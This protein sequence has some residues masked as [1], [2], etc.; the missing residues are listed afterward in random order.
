MKKIL[1]LGDSIR[2]GYE[3]YVKQSFDGV[4]DVYFP[5]VNCAFA[6][7]MLR[8]LNIWKNEQKIPDD[9]DLVHFNVGLWDVLRIYDDGTLTSPEY[10]AEILPRIIKRIKILFP[11]A[12]IVFALSTNVYEE[13]YKTTPPYARLNADVEKFNKIAVD[14]L[15][16]LGVFINDLYAITKDLPA[17]S[18][19]R[20][21]MTHFNTDDGVN[22]LGGQV[23]KTIC[24]LLDIPLESINKI[25]AK[26]RIISE[27][28]L[29][30]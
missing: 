8:Y 22:L 4:V 2:M 5:N 7:N 1:L 9:I 6:Q 16:P 13:G 12:K 10:Y 11:K 19:C 26:G 18:S 14:V 17:D 25:S 30:N 21:D 3:E 23:T 20:S 24:S 29:R 15:T 28:V 27:K